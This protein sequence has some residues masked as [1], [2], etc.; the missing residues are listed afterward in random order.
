[1]RIARFFK[2]K[3]GSMLILILIF[4][5]MFL[6]IL[7]GI[8]SVGL[9][10]KKVNN[11][12][13]AD[14]EALHIAEAGVQYYKWFLLH[15]PTVFNNN[16]QDRC[17]SGN[18]VCTS[19]IS[20]TPATAEYATAT[21]VKRC[22]TGY[23]GPYVRNY[24]FTDGNGVNTTG[25]YKLCI[26]PPLSSDP[27]IVVQST[28]YITKYKG[29]NY[30]G[31]KAINRTIEVGYSRPS[32][33]RYLALSNGGALRI[34]PDTTINGPIH[35][36]EGIRL[37]TTGINLRPGEM[38]TSH[39]RWY[40]DK[41]HLI[42]ILDEFGVHSHNGGA[43]IT[44]PQLQ[45]S[46]CNKSPLQNCDV[47]Q[48]TISPS[49]TDGVYYMNEIAQLRGQRAI[50]A[51][52]IDFINTSVTKDYIA[53]GSASMRGKAGTALFYCN[54]SNRLYAGG[55]AISPTIDCSKGVEIKIKDN[56]TY[57]VCGVTDFTADE[58]DKCTF[59]GRRQ[60]I[61]EWLS[62]SIKTRSNC[63]DFNAPPN[64]VI[65][66]EFA[67]NPGG[68]EYVNIN[69]RGDGGNV[70]GLCLW[71]GFDYNDNNNKF[72]AHK[73][74][75]VR[76]DG[77]SPIN[78]TNLTI[79]AFAASTTINN[80]DWTDIVINNNIRCAQSGGNININ[81]NIGL[82]AQHDI[83]IGQQSDDNLEIDAALIARTGGIFRRAYS[84]PLLQC[85]DNILRNQLTINGSLIANKT[86]VP[87]RYLLCAQTSPTVVG[88]QFF[89]TN[90]YDITTIPE[91]NSGYEHVTL[92]YNRNFSTNPPPSW[93]TLGEYSFSYWKEY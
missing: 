28:G 10:Q 59:S 23:N 44:L 45:E 89:H 6:S 70:T 13:V 3:K 85:H 47:P 14:I 52:I 17:V 1:M 34:S 72:I 56:N 53:S 20:T 74:V 18:S 26:K 39:Q 49:S 30:T 43:G 37:D 75:W 65:Y 93:P 90:P 4:T 87:N 29:V 62:D 46:V 83:I 32:L 24:S 66:F 54:S 60:A 12:K 61:C 71:G 11:K 67:N 33:S 88:F 63:K 21:Q 64:G 27:T 5:S 35:S 36:N 55:S 82:I 7:T 73:K 91:L 9:W 78:N 2:F 80:A 38:I 76:S 51:P 57:N 25:K 40:S 22:P 41:T 48:K 68:D 79:L 50:N 15:N 69:K 19:A 31:Y 84:C 16:N 81:C 77:N 58:D 92:S 42:K 86:T 8:L